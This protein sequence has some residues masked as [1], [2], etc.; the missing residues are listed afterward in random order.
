M[1]QN[2]PMNQ[3]VRMKNGNSGNKMECRSD[4]IVIVS[5]SDDI[6]VR[7][8][9]EQDWVLKFLF[10]GGPTSSTHQR[11]NHQRE[12][13]PKCNYLIYFFLCRTIDQISLSSP[14]GEYK[15]KTSDP[16]TILFTGIL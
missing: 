3:I 12:H 8:I 10:R 6:R 5:V 13:R 1:P 2:R 15:A 11:A 9:R 7:V 4:E 14:T 16:P